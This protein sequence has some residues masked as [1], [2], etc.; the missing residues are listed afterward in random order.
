[1]I[2]PNQKKVEDLIQLDLGYIPDV[3]IA[4]YR[5]IIYILYKD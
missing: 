3:N 4:D 2:P 5:S 1:M